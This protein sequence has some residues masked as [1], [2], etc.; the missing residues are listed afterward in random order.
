MKVYIIIA[1][2]IIFFGMILLLRYT[3]NKEFETL[4]DENELE[5]IP[6][7]IIDKLT[8]YDAI[9]ESNTKML[10]TLDYQYEKEKDY[11]KRQKILTR[12][13]ALQLKIS[14][15]AEKADKLRDKYN[16]LE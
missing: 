12:Q 11:M 7:Y 8:A 4:E 14:N 16:I 10:F 13:A 5:E 9:I 15:A 6:N 3:K 2:I 1:W